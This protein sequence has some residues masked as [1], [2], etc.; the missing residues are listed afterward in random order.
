MS[1]IR[2]YVLVDLNDVEQ[3]YEY[4]SF[5][6]AKSTAAKLGDH[7][8]IERVYEYADSGLVWTPN[9]E[10]ASWPPKGGAA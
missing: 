7:A 8:V 4:E 1:D 5:D 10:Y 3:D 9:G 2:R 6:E